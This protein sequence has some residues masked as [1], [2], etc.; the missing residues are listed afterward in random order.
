MPIGYLTP[1]QILWLDSTLAKVGTKPEKE[2][3]T[4]ITAVV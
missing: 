1:E 2:A 4:E 3:P